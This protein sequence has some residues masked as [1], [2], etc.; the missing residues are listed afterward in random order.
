ME[1]IL[2]YITDNYV[3]VMIGLFLFIMFVVGYIADATDFG[4][5]KNGTKKPKKESKIK[6]KKVE[7]NLDTPIDNTP[8][9]EDLNV[10][11][12][13]AGSLSE[14]T[15]DYKILDEDL[16]APLES[17]S[18]DNLNSPLEDT[19]PVEDLNAPLEDT[20]YVSNAV[21]PDGPNTADVVIPTDDLYAPIEDTTMSND[22]S[23]DEILIP[24][25]DSSIPSATESNDDVLIPTDDLYAPIEDTTIIPSATEPDETII[26]EQNDEVIISNEE[27]LDKTQVIPVDEDFTPLENINEISV[28]ESKKKK[29]EKS[30]KKKKKKEELVPEI[31]TEDINGD[32]SSDDD[33]WKF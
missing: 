10:P 11:F 27:E 13:D 3:A 2:L 1:D 17:T 30:S 28:E 18:M 16:N 14:S 25:E 31:I 7:E 6:N 24:T 32:V 12:G 33:I 9:N 15:N 4:R 8:L 5:D 29:K 26:P 23:S 21:I 20:S 19:M 22:T